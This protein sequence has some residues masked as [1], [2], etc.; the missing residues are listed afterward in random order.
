PR[1]Q[2]VQL[3]V[4]VT[5]QRLSGL[6]R[7]PVATL[8]SGHARRRSLG[9][10]FFTS[11]GHATSRTRPREQGLPEY[12]LPTGSR[13]LGGLR[14]A[15]VILDV[16]GHPHPGPFLGRIGARGDDVLDHP[17]QFL[18]LALRIHEHGAG[19]HHAYRPP[20]GFQ[21]FDPVTVPATQTGFG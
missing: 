10:R 15:V 21:T 20:A 7:R 4:T 18:R 17:G 14:C 8:L 19:V 11:H 13:P 16:L 3:V 12:L 6:D 9:H 5:A 2:G 1:R